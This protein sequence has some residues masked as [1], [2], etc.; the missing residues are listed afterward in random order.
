LF[1]FAYRV[2]QT[3]WTAQRKKGKISE[4]E[5]LDFLLELGRCITRRP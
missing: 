5:E 4:V 3:K 2:R 1:F